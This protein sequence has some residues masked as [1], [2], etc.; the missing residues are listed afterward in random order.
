MLRKKN[1][2]VLISGVGSN[3]Q[4]IVDACAD[5]DFPAAVA[6][7]ISS[8]ASA[9]GLKRAKRHRIPSVVTT[10]ESDF[11]PLMTR[12]DIRFLC[13]AGY[14]KILS[15]DFVRR[16]YG[17]I[18]NIHPSLLPQFP[19]RK[20]IEKAWRAGVK[21]TGVT[22]HFVDEGIDTGPIVLQESISIKEGESL[23]SLEARIHALEHRL[24][25]Q[26]IR[27]VSLTQVSQTQM[28]LTQVI[29]HLKPD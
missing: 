23:E 20:A 14:M 27:Q 6:L 16:F 13:L 18:L 1:L 7:V 11:I 24:Y 22:I 3:L 8:N 15:P 17:R 12:Y 28:S 25:P 10:A 26:A 4:A 29:D 21:E 9:Y 19:G 5:P 2:A